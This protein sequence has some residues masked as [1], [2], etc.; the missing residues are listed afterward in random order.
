MDNVHV[1]NVRMANKNN[2]TVRQT[3]VIDIFE[4]WVENPKA[5]ITNTGIR[6][7]SAVTKISER[8]SLFVIGAV[9]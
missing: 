1:R 8:G 9:C 5:G 3:S 4:N 6:N 7:V 2:N